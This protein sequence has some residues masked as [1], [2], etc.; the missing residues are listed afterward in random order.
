MNYNN[1]EFPNSSV[2][3]CNLF[4]FLVSDL[5]KR[6]LCSMSLN[7]NLTKE[8]SISLGPNQIDLKTSWQPWV[9][10]EKGLFSEC[11]GVAEGFCL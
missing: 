1:D 2:L 8:E 10:K 4:P 5:F 3:P 11:I 6:M 7:G 9:T